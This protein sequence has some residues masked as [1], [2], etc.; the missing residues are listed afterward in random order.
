LPKK[1]VFACNGRINK[2]PM[3]P[4]HKE[5]ER[6]NARIAERTGF[7]DVRGAKS[8][9]SQSA[10]SGP[11]LS[12]FRMGIVCTRFYQINSYFVIFKKFLTG[13]AIIASAG[14]VPTSLLLQNYKSVCL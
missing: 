10:L 6:I 8:L 11:G 14:R 12:R 3:Q 13:S 9:F 1:P 2:A 4:K 7:A 5:H